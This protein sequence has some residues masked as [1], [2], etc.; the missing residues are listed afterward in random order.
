M[1]INELDMCNDLIYEDQYKYS[2]SLMAI[3]DI[4]KKQNKV[5]DL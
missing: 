2:E 4:Y 1:Y 3:C 5:S